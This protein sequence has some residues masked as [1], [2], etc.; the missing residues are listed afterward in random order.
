MSW[1]QSSARGFTYRAVVKTRV[2]LEKRAGAIPAFKRFVAAPARRNLSWLA[3]VYGSDKGATAH[4][5]VDLYEHHL[6]AERRRY[7][8]VLEIGVYKGASLQMWRDYFPHA[9]VVGI[10]IERVQV[11]G[12]R[13]RTLQGDQSDPEVL[14]ELRAMGPW[15]LIVDDGSHRAPH[16]HASFAGLYDAV[17]P[18]GFY[19]IEDLH[20][21]Y[22]ER[23]YGGGPPGHP[24]TG[25]DLLKQL[26][27]GV[28]RPFAAEHYP[29]EAL[30][31]TGVSEL[32]VYPKIAFV[33]HP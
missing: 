5:Y 23:G 29:T 17:R 11:P 31:L 3:A 14:A 1:L 22:W 18:G 6:E 15:D 12:P 13:I 26:V 30:G 33:R 32:H 21:S 24:G 28:H 10:D 19:V 7:R 27:D 20:T 16:V 9:E 8:R 25:V 2:E 4:R